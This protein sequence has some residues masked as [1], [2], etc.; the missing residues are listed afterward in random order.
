MWFVNACLWAV[1]RRWYGGGFDEK[2]SWLGNRG[3]Q[4]FVMISVLFFTLLDSLIWWQALLLALWIQFQ[5]W[6]R[7]VGEILDC[8][9]STVQNAESYD[10]WF[11]IPLDW[12]YDKL[13][14]QKYVGAYDWWY[15]ELRYSLPMLVPCL[16]LGEG[17]FLIVGLLAAPVYF[18]C[19]YVFETFPLL[20]RLPKWAAEPKNLAELLYGFLFGA[21]LW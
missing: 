19:W 15:T 20:F 17:R 6:S 2:Y 5:F 4:T 1:L 12:G 13:G 18:F 7:A 21:L 14:K 8:G 3:L 11:R 9:R 10:R 16:C